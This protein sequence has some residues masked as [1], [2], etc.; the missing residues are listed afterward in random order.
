MHEGSHHYEVKYKISMIK[1][2]GEMKQPFRDKFG[3]Q[4]FKV[5]FGTTYVG[6]EI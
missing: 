1:S 2:M 5:A 6:I 3:Q 4:I